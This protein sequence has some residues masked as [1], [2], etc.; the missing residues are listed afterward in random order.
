MSGDNRI[1][2]DLSL[3]S[4]D[5]LIAE[6]HKRFDIFIFSGMQFRRVGGEEL[7]TVRRWSGNKATCAGL[8][9]QLQIALYDTQCAEAVDGE[10]GKTFEQ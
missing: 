2:N 1:S 3:V 8:A 9:S 4:F 10:E 5:D 7:N 6:L